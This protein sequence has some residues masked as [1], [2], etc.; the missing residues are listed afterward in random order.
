MSPHNIGFNAE[1]CKI[2]PYHH[3]NTLTL[4]LLKPSG[5]MLWVFI[6]TAFFLMWV[7]FKIA[8]FLRMTILH[9]VSIC[10]NGNYVVSILSIV[11]PKQGNSNEYPQHKVLIETL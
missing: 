7:F 11:L 6:R 4:L 2:I 1:I 3:I 9:D 10:W 8:A 5:L